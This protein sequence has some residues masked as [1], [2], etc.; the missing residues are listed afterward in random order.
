MPT[1]YERL[2][3]IVAALIPSEAVF[4]VEKIIDRTIFIKRIIVKQSERKELIEDKELLT[5]LTDHVAEGWDS[6]TGKY[7]NNGS[8]SALWLHIKHSVISEYE[9][10]SKRCAATKQKT[11]QFIRNID[12]NNIHLSNYIIQVFLRINTSAYDTSNTLVRKELFEQF[13]SLR[14]TYGKRK[15]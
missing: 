5:L 8:V 1:P 9:Y 4:R 14:R 2:D 13:E 7:F 6:V 11:E 3:R 15:Q 12:I 10:V